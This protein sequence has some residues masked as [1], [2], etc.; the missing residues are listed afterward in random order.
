M[1]GAKEKEN[2]ID[3]EIYLNWISIEIEKVKKEDFQG[4]EYF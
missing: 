4:L 3:A 2:E 1:Y